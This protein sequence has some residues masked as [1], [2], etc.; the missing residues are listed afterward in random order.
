M[1]TREPTVTV[2]AVDPSDTLAVLKA[3]RVWLGTPE[4]WTTRVLWRGADGKALARASNTIEPGDCPFVAS[5]CA[6]GA[7]FLV[8]GGEFPDAVVA[9]LTE[10]MPRGIVPNQ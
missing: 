5:T 10:A 2:E 4:H 3:A 8:T 7:I 1:T 6:S 9:A